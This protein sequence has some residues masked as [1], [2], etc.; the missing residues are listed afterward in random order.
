M[1]RLYEWTPDECIP[2]FYT[3]PTIFVSMHPDMDNLGIPDWAENVEDFIR[4]HR[5]ALEDEHV[6]EFLHNWIDLTFGYKLTG[7]PA[8]LSKAF[9]YADFVLTP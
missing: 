3:D 6:S 2:E 1:E 4:K 5:E 8:I 7:E 9:T